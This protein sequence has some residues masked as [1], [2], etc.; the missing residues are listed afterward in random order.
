VVEKDRVQIIFPVVSPVVTI[1][2]KGQSRAKAQ[3]TRTGPQEENIQWLKLGLLFMNFV[4]APRLSQS[5]LIRMLAASRGQ[6]IFSRITSMVPG[7]TT[8]ASHS[9][10]LKL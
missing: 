9:L 10:K 4:P 2:G 7:S 5:Q 1:T 6:R 8:N 3:T